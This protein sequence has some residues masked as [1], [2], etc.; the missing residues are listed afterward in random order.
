MQ[1]RRE[2]SVIT[3]SLDDRGGN[4]NAVQAR[5]QRWIEGKSWQDFR[6]FSEVGIER[7]L[8]KN[9]KFRIHQRSKEA[10]IERYRGTE[11]ESGLCKEQKEGSGKL[12][13]SPP[14]LRGETRMQRLGSRSTRDPGRRHRP[15][16]SSRE[17][18]VTGESFFLPGVLTR[19]QPGC[20]A[21]HLLRPPFVFLVTLRGQH[22]CH[23]HVMNKEIDA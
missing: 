7:S 10:A 22:S 1:V 14:A 17:A 13:V 11:R 12:R 3:M 19:C 15:S 20:S 2:G 9:G 18:S 21:Y 8:K 5:E 23:L 4:S 16:L 6:N